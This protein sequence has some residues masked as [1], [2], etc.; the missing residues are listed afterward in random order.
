ML[1]VRDGAVICYML[2]MVQLHVRDGAVTCY[3]LG[4][5]Q[6]HVTC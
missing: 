3:M 6:L 4:M 5:V 2:G 1:H